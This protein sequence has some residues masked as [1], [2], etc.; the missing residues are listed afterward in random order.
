MHGC[1]LRVYEWLAVS[2]CNPRFTTKNCLWSCCIFML[3]SCFSDVLVF[4]VVS[5]ILC[6]YLNYWHPPLDCSTAEKLVWKVICRIFSNL[7]NQS[8]CA[9]SSGIIASSDN[10]LLIYQS[11]KP[12]NALMISTDAF[13]FFFLPFKTFV[14]N[15]WSNNNERMLQ[16]VSTRYPPPPFWTTHSEF[17]YITSHV[18]CVSFLRSSL[19]YTSSMRA[20]YLANSRPDPNNPPAQ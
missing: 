12:L 3:C 15:F 7:M 10:F 8:F 16:E 17:A 18:L 19:Q 11:S 2:I 20:K 1:I 5:V 9:C 4:V 6:L 13:F 14:F